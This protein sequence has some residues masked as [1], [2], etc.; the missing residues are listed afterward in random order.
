MQ[1]RIVADHQDRAQA[2][3]ELAEPAHQSGAAGEIEP[4]LEPDRW[5]RGEMGEHQRGGFPRAQRGRAQHEI[6]RAERRWQARADPARRLA[7][8]PVQLAL[9][10]L[11]RLVAIRFGVAQQVQPVHRAR[12]VVGLAR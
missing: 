1:P 8:A 11:H 2:L 12:P 9:V 10:I 7:A 6:E 3:V 4:I 5:W